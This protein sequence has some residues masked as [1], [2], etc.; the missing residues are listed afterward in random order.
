MV[1]SKFSTGFPQGCGKYVKTE[2]KIEFS[3][4]KVRKS[5]NC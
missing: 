2:E 4:L 1:F 3:V 5:N